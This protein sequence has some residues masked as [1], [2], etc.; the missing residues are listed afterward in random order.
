LALAVV[1]VADEEHEMSGYPIIMNGDH[2]EFEPERPLPRERRGDAGGRVLS[3]LNSCE[4]FKIRTP[5][6]DLGFVLGR[7]R[8]LSPHAGLPCGGKHPESTNAALRDRGFLAHRYLTAWTLCPAAPGST[9]GE[10]TDCHYASEVRHGITSS[11][12]LETGLKHTMAPHAALHSIGCNL[13]GRI[14]VRQEL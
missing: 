5:C 14:G 10:G 6:R 8:G 1:A 4:L 3:R 2:A 12:D 9:A 11:L 13:H 7:W